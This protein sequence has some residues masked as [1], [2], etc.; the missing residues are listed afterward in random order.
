MQR[1]RLTQC[2]LETIC[3]NVP[4]DDVAFLGHCEEALAVRAFGERVEFV[5]MRVNTLPRFKR[6]LLLF[7][8]LLSECG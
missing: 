5:S 7:A 8:L 2:S 1:T 4:N 3:G 6:E